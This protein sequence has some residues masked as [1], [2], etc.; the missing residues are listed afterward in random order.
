MWAMVLLVGVIA[1][2][3]T[4]IH[5][6]IQDLIIVLIS[7]PKGIPYREG[8][9]GVQLELGELLRHDA[10]VVHGVVQLNVLAFEGGLDAVEEAGFPGS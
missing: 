6:A 4:T 3:K 1:L 9:C 2:L 10:L 5:Q 8:L 7:N